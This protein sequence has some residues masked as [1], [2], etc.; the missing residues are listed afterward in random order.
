[1]SYNL[2]SDFTKILDLIK[3]KSDSADSETTS[4]LNNLLSSNGLELKECLATVSFDFN[5]DKTT[6]KYNVLKYDRKK[7]KPEEFSTK[8]MLR[9]LVLNDKGKMLAFAPPKMVHPSEEALASYSVNDLTA[10]NHIVAEMLVEGIMFNLFYD[11]VSV[12][13]NEPGTEAEAEAE[14]EAGAEDAKQE[15]T[16]SYGFW[17]V[18]TKSCV[19]A[20][21][22]PEIQRETT[23][24]TLR[25]R[26]FE[27][28]QASGVSLDKLPRNMS[29]SFVL[30][31]PK[32]P[33][34]HYIEKPVLYLIAA[35]VLDSDTYSIHELSHDNEVLT[36]IFSGT[37]VWFPAMLTSRPH[38]LEQEA[39]TALTKPRETIADFKALY[40]SGQTGVE[41]PGVVFH[42]KTTNER[43]KFRN[44]KYEIVKHRRGKD[45]KLMMQYLHLRKDH[46][47]QEYLV[48]FPHHADLFNEFRRKI[49][50]YTNS[51]YETYVKCYVKKEKPL[52]QFPGEV[53]TH[54]FK[55]HHDIYLAD[56]RAKGQFVS[57]AT[58]IHYVNN[59]APAQQ[60]ACL[61]MTG[62]KHVKPAGSGC[63][64][65][66]ETISETTTGCETSGENSKVNDDTGHDNCEFA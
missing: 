47:V 35:Y 55:L 54:A 13:M 50:D 5:G 12:V 45:T 42:N 9:S 38:T 14:A 24:S 60:L 3:K 63:A 11:E 29:Y 20:H 31:H 28:I 49:H 39:E 10:S 48:G 64:N 46:R 51:L 62:Y 6:K 17:E 30:Q 26:F 43:F 66:N 8:G 58:V 21:L 4:E 41:Y 56:L 36:H 25:A 22:M 2:D 32:N 65:V 1:M 18:A 16:M 53:R 44:P 23:Q 27:G 59:L 37:K 19:G 33:I 34:V 57:K 40:A 15:K 7:L 52:N 61:N